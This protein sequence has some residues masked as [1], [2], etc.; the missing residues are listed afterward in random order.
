[1]TDQAQPKK[2]PGFKTSEFWLS[3][4]ATIL[5]IALASGLIADGGTAAQIVGGA[6]SILASLGYTASRTQV[7]VAEKA[8]EVQEDGAV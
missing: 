7:K 3:S 8:S 5:G 4:T 6:L 1:M 2:R